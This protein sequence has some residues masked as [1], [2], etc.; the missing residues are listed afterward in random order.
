[1]PHQND[2]SASPPGSPR[3]RCSSGTHLSSLPV[4]GLRPE[5]CHRNQPRRVC[6]SRHLTLCFVPGSLA[7]KPTPLS[8]FSAL[9]RGSMPRVPVGA[10]WMLGSRPSMT[11][12]GVSTKSYS[13]RR[14]CRGMRSTNRTKQYRHLGRTDFMRMF[15]RA[16]TPLHPHQ[17]SL[18]GVSSKTI[19]VA[20]H[21]T[22][23]R[24]AECDR[25]LIFH[26]CLRRETARRLLI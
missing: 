12:G 13:R 17:V 7:E 19:A 1:M 26:N 15:H 4:L 3:H 18:A 8:V 2:P 16:C 21:Q 24:C 25:G 14:A 5:G 6:V 20:R 9:S 10:V 11:E 23:V 22:S